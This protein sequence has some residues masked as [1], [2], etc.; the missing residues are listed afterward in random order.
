MKILYLGPFKENSEM[1]D[2]AQDDLFCLQKHF[3]VVTEDGDLSNVDTIIQYGKIEN[4]QRFCKK[5]HIGYVDVFDPD[6]AIHVAKANMM[7][8]LWIASMFKLSNR[9]DEHVDQYSKIKVPIYI[10]PHFINKENYDPSLRMNI[11]EIDAF[12]KLLYVDNDGDKNAVKEEI[13]KF[14][15]QYDA[16]RPV[17][18]IV[19]SQIDVGSI[20]DE[21]KS[22]LNLYSDKNYYQTIY[23]VSEEMN[24]TQRLALYNYC[25]NIKYSLKKH[26]SWYSEVMNAALY[27]KYDINIDGYDERIFLERLN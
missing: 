14:Y 1:G 16:T 23:I 15:K 7:D 5:K 25:D 9:V 21:L 11:P 27:K 12:Y 8:E 26:K 17:A 20:V 19:R 4:F 13:E 22:E 10:V 6:N 24:K 2:T 18:L 3:E